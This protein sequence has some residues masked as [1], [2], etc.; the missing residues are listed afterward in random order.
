MYGFVKF[1][2]HWNQVIRSDGTNNNL[3][4]ERSD[5]YACV[6]L[7]QMKYKIHINDW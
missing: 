6:C 1:I 5:Y 3:K 2:K 4:I 7:Q